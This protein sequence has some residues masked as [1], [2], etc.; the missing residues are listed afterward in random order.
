M[1]RIQI[2]QLLKKTD[3]LQ[4]F[5]KEM[6]NGAVAVIP[7]DTLYGFAVDSNSVEAVSRIYQ[8]KNR[9]EQKPL[10]LFLDSHTKLDK[11]K[12]EQT[13]EQKAILQKYWPG[14]LTA[15]F[16]KP[17]CDGLLGFSY[18]TIGLRVP[19]HSG[20]LELLKS[21]PGMFLTT[22]ANRSGQPSS[23][24]PESIFSE[25]CQEI[26]WLIEDGE[27]AE[28]IASTVLD[29]TASPFKILRMGAVNPEQ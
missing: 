26:D 2:D 1:K 15:I 9:S 4:E 29:M 28:G 10:I 12:I 24:D 27:M 6:K 20:L 25:F 8:I 18:P 16:P 5:F 23:S 21:Y 22:S 17:E 19:G 13:Q 7:T 3:R 11:L 14:A